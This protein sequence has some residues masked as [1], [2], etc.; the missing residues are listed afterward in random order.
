MMILLLAALTAPTA[1]LSGQAIAPGKTC[2]T[3]SRVLPEGPRPFGKMSQVVE[4]RRFNG[5]D[6]LEISTHQQITSPRGVINMKDVYLVR[7]TDLRPLSYR[8]TTDGRTTIDLVYEERRVVG[9]RDKV[10]GPKDNKGE[11]I[12]VDLPLSGPVWDQGLWGETI[13]ALPLKRNG[14]YKVPSYH[15]AKGL[16]EMTFKVVGEQMIDTPGGRERAWV[17]DAYTDPALVARYYIAK[18]GRKELG[19]LAGGISQS[20]SESCPIDT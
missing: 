11:K 12:A 3:M 10:M 4:R 6:A 15:Y 7:R 18:K 20:L 16:G 17:V 8:N 2:Y 13:A 1:P 5:V 9:T 14:S 19:Y